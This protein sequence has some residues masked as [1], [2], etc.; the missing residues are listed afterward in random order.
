MRRSRGPLY[1]FKGTLYYILSRGTSLSSFSLPLFSTR[2]CDCFH[3]LASTVLLSRKTPPRLAAT[4]CVKRRPSR[5]KEILAHSPLGV[6][7][8]YGH[9]CL[10]SP[11]S[12]QKN[13]GSR[14]HVS[15][16]RMPCAGH[17]ARLLPEPAAE[18]RHRGA[19]WRC[20]RDCASFGD[21]Q[22]VMVLY[23]LSCGG[24]CT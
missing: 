23:V 10:S 24:V 8:I 22:E 14:M 19:I 13:V 17:D 5:Q 18:H 21:S 7:K 1:K 6:T 16:A 9:L 12:F 20:G 11:R 4:S 3:H 2:V 15:D